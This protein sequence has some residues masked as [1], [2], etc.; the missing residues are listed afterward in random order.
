[1]TGTVGDRALRALIAF[2][3]AAIAIVLLLQLVPQ[4][5]GGWTTSW[6]LQPG[7]S[8]VQII[9]SF[10]PNTLLVVLLAT[11]ISAPLATLLG[12]RAGIRSRAPLLDSL[13][14]FGASLPVFW[15][16]LMLAIVALQMGPGFLLVGE[17]GPTRPGTGD[18][19]QIA[20]ALLLERVLGAVL[21]AL[22]LSMVGIAT[23]SR[24]VRSSVRETQDRPYVQMARARGLPQQVI[25]Q[26]Y[27]RSASHSL[28]SALIRA[29]PALVGGTIVVETV[30][31]Y[32][33]LGWLFVQALRSNDWPIVAGLLLL[34]AL[35]I[36]IATTLDG[37]VR[38]NARRRTYA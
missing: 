36:A 21:P 18:I 9:A 20:D 15:L 29:L 13:T 32:P 19:N 2:V 17:I 1:M 5:G 37:V 26:R 31:G 35:L 34:L 28:S 22:T 10:L 7:M 4:V 11:L 6:A 23:V 3:V 27:A 16:G 33:G 25:N 8:V 30:F 38:G 24:W 12:T 14:L